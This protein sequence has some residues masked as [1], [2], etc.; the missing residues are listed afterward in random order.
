MRVWPLLLFSLC[1]CGDTPLRS[2]WADLSRRLPAGDPI[3]A[4]ATE[5]T[6]QGP[7]LRVRVGERTANAALLPEQGDRRLWRA[8]AGIVGATDGGRV[9]APRGR[10]EVWLAPR[11]DGRAPL[12][13]PADLLD[14]PAEARRLVDLMRSDR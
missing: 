4:E 6:A 1:G 13:S 5:S 11:L 14:H 2:A 8:V 7:A 10:R 3:P 9:A 12:G